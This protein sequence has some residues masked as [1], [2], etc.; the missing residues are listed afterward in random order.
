M[1][2]PALEDKL[3]ITVGTQQQNEALVKA[4]KELV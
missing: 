3:R 2:Q 1:L 4:L